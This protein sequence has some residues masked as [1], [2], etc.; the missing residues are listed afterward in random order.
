[1][2][3]Q[4]GQ[5]LVGRTIQNTEAT[6]PIKYNVLERLYTNGVVD[7]YLVTQ[8][9]VNVKV[10]LKAIKPALT[11][12]VG[13]SA[14]FIAQ[15]KA[16][17][18]IN[19]P[20]MTKLYDYGRDGANFFYVVEHHKS[21]TVRERIDKEGPFPL[22]LALD[23]V[24]IMVDSLGYAA[25]GEMLHGLLSPLSLVITSRRGPLIS[26]FGLSVL[27]G[28]LLPGVLVNTPQLSSYAAPEVLFG[29]PV[30]TT[31]D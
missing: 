15:A 8:A 17:L 10:E 6:T 30:S 2:N 14:R 24:R 7:T 26:D 23:Y 5:S 27:L 29:Q 13:F 28:E 11:A 19:A 25:S 16:L 22:L 18:S 1:M 12:Q 4:V 31:S 21:P 3:S 20:N 9:A